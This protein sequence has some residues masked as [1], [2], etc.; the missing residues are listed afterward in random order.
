MVSP[1][2]VS[3][4]ARVVSWVATVLLVVGLVNGVAAVLRRLRGDADDRRQKPLGATT[5]PRW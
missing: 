3:T 5:D 4:P 2:E 1:A